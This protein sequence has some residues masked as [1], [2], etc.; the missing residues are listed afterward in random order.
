MLTAVC[1]APS[2]SLQVGV[3]VWVGFV[4]WLDGGGACTRMHTRVCVGLPVTTRA[5]AC[6]R[7]YVC[8]CGCMRVYRVY[9]RVCANTHTEVDAYRVFRYRHEKRR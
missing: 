6:I 8:D 5:C 2:C 7:V 3:F 1:A 9:T 4:W